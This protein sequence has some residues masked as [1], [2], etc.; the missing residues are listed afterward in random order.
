MSVATVIHSREK[1]GG[2]LQWCSEPLATVLLKKE[3][4]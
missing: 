3:A 4:G 1:A 2:L